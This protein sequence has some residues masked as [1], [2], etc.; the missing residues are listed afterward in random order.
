MGR[1]EVTGSV[2]AGQPEVT[3]RADIGPLPTLVELLGDLAARGV[4]YCHWKSNQHLAAGLAGM[5]DLDLLVEL[6]Q[7]SLFREVMARHGLKRLMPPAHRAYPGIEHYIGLDRGTGR[8]FH[9]HV[10]FQLVLGD[11]HVKNYRIPVEQV[12]LDSVRLLDGVPVPSPELELAILSM[13]AL[14]KYRIRD[15]VKDVLGIRSPGLAGQIRSELDWLLRQTGIR[16]VSAALHVAGRPVPSGIICEFL[17]TFQRDPRSGMRLLRLRGRLRRA[18]AGLERESRLRAAIRYRRAV[19]VARLW[20]QPQAK[21][22]PETGGLTIALVGSD[23]SGKST[24]ARELVWWLSWKI[25][26]RNYYLGSTSPSPPS[27]W[28]YAAFRA[29]RRGERSIGRRLGDRSRIRAAVAAVRDVVL[30]FHHLAIGLER[31]RRHRAG[32]RDARAGRVVI[33]DRF[34]LATLSARPELRLLD[35]PKI[36]ATFSGS[37]GR[38]TRALA[39]AEERLY[40][41]FGLPD[42]LMVLHVTPGVAAARK[43]DHRQEVLEAKTKATVGLAALAE[44]RMEPGRV[45]PIDADQPLPSVLLDVK[46]KVWDAV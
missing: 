43:P 46:L 7:A 34:P 19:W 8:M 29:L 42:R 39:A 15:A 33:F 14:L 22:R 28:L 41:G 13:R 17:E 26:V 4:R 45:V 24:V 3:S 12:V 10:H 5:T 6:D 21:M 20:R 44:R 23:G 27:R 35:A 36:A 18:V 16:E 30:C 38:L 11:R 1:F 32:H 2:L 40:R 25:D 37:G 31:R 9:L